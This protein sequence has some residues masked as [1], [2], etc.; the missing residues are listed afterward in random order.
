MNVPVPYKKRMLEEARAAEKRKEQESQK[1]ER[2]EAV[3]T[4]TTAVST[5]SSTPTVTTAAQPLPLKAAI[6]ASALGTT[7]KSSAAEDME[8]QAKR[9]KVERIV[10]NTTRAE[11]IFFGDHRG[12]FCN[13]ESIERLLAVIAAFGWGRWEAVAEGE[14]CSVCRSRNRFISRWMLGV[15]FMMLGLGL[16]GGYY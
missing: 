14:D 6:L 5:S 16:Y 9:A 12:L 8:P 10:V 2:E 11:E 15:W 1:R 13:A 7:A 3:T 4:V